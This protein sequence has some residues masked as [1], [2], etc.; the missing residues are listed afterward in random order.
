MGVEGG[1]GG[2]ADEVVVLNVVA[3]PRAYSNQAVNDMTA[4][5]AQ[6]T[7]ASGTLTVPQMQRIQRML[8]G[9]PLTRKGLLRKLLFSKAAAPAKAA[10]EADAAAEAT[11][12]AK[13]KAAAEAEASAEATAAAAAKTAAGFKEAAASQA[14]DE[15]R[16]AAAEATA[17]AADY[18]PRYDANHLRRHYLS[19]ICIV[20]LI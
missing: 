8:G 14:A 9:P 1:E 11:A 13:A 18:P 10:G 6:A 5:Q 19:F 20:Y 17:A 3:E 12:A 15:A 2:A 4:D 7:V 16:R